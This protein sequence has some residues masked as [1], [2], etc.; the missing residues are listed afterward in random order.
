MATV[1]GYPTKDAIMYGSFLG[2]AAL[3]ATVFNGTPVVMGVIIV[4][5]MVGM[6]LYAHG[7][8]QLRFDGEPNWAMGVIVGVFTV[9]FG[10][11][12]SL[13][14]WYLEPLIF[15]PIF[16]ITIQVGM[17]LAVKRWGTYYVQELQD[18]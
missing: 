16:A 8:G 12:A 9:V 14:N 2:V 1:K 11:G 13:I 6:L 18:A 5:A 10:M 4:M 3:A 15:G 17:A 7:T